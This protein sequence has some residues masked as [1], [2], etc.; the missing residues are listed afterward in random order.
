[1]FDYPDDHPIRL[2]RYKRALLREKSDFSNIVCPKAAKIS[3]I[4]NSSYVILDHCTVKIV[5]DK[6]KKIWP[7]C[8]PKH[9]CLSVEIQ[10]YLSI[11]FTALENRVARDY[12]NFKIVHG[13]LIHAIASPVANFSYLLR[14][15]DY[16][17]NNV[18]CILKFN[19][20]L[21]SFHKHGSTSAQP[22][23]VSG[24]AH[25]I[26]QEYY[27]KIR[28]DPALVDTYIDR[29]YVELV[30]WLFSKYYAYYDKR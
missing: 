28:V 23:I 11:R 14:N 26:P 27:S 10:R 1:M 24:L 19:G 17:F 21:Y 15:R 13:G 7:L 18:S 5:K 9:E 8:Y 6:K 12:Q 22:S 30:D 3:N 4:L 29:Y 25:L 2:P 20:N 16:S